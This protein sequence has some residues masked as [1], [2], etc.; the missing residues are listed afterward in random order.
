MKKYNPIVVR[1]TGRLIWLVTYV[2]AFTVRCTFIGSDTLEN[3]MSKTAIV[4][5]F[6]HG[7]FFILPYLHRRK[8]VALIVSQSADGDIS[9]ATVR[10]YGFAIIRG[11]STRGAEAAALGVVDYIKNGYTVA[12][13]GDGPKGPYHEL[14]AGPVW[15]AQKMNIP[16]IPVTIR[17]KRCI[18]LSSWDKFFIPI[19]FTRAIVIYGEPVS[20]QGLQRREGMRIVQQHME[21]QE[22][23]AEKMLGIADP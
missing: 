21:Q 6:W 12:I 13:T 16:L 1:I 7:E 14:K 23:M 5:V 4:G 10:H 8:K 2:I 3:V 18:Q 19:P 9:A 22:A 11:S 17:L 20:M 15:F